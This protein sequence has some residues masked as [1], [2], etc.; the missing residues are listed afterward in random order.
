MK[1]DINLIYIHLIFA[2]CFRI[3]DCSLAHVLGVMTDLILVCIEVIYNLNIY[4]S[5]RFRAWNFSEPSLSMLENCTLTSF[6]FNI[7]YL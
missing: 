6:T 7:Q 5:R 1:L 3:Y 4:R 2:T